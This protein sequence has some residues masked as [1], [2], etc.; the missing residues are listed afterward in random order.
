MQ[1]HIFVLEQKSLEYIDQ[2]SLHL[3]PSSINP[4]KAHLMET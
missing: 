3:F 1:T 2:A 4:S